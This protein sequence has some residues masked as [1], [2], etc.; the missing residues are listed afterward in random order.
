MM[1]L[2]VLCGGR[3]NGNEMIH[4]VVSVCVLYWT[5]AILECFFPE[6]DVDTQIWYY[7][8]IFGDILLVNHFCHSVLN[9][10]FSESSE[11]SNF[12]K[13]LLSNMLL[14][15][16]LIHLLSGDRHLCHW[17]LNLDWRTRTVGERPFPEWQL[18]NSFQFKAYH[19]H[20]KGR[21]CRRGKHCAVLRPWLHQ[22]RLLQRCGLLGLFRQDGPLLPQPPNVLQA[23]GSVSSLWMHWTSSRKWRMFRFQ[24]SVSAMQCR[25]FWSHP[26]QQGGARCVDCSWSHHL[27]Q[28]GM[29]CQDWWYS[30]QGRWLC[31]FQR[32][33]TCLRELWENEGMHVVQH[34]V[35]ID[36]KK[37]VFWRWALEKSVLSIEHVCDK[38]TSK[39][40]K[41][42]F[43]MSGIY[44]Y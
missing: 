28:S 42:K 10:D 35:I 17:F 23:I 39:K 19:H 27:P 16:D 15:F 33:G 26:M 22:L 43:C 40:F 4:V 7:I 12:R 13:F 14:S 34:Q 24:H 41:S 2:L 29:L 1:N 20:G 32:D 18:H 37:K 30:R 9:L 6:Q 3:L 44:S 38:D 25:H 36:L 11:S 8:T 31:Q 21:R 5:S